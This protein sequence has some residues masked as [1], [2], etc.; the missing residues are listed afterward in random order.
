MANTLVIY[1][2][3]GK[4]RISKPFRIAD[5]YSTVDG[6]RTRLS[7]HCFETLEEAETFIDAARKEGHCA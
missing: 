7:S 2:L 4:V 1:M 3:V 6:A 5:V